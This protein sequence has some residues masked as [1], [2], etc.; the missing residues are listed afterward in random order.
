MLIWGRPV[1][2]LNTESQS[3][4]CLWDSLHKSTNKQWVRILSVYTHT[5]KTLK[6]PLVP[7][8]AE[9]DPPTRL[10]LTTNHSTALCYNV[11]LLI[12]INYVT[13]FNSYGM[14]HDKLLLCCFFMPSA[15]AVWKG[16][17]CMHFFNWIII[18]YFYM[19]KKGVLFSRMNEW[20][21]K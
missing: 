5:R 2:N 16:L 12:A 14:Q 20:M 9:W 3:S 13:F 1:L 8:P 7:E 17:A 4:F 15:D 18:F 21:H 6:T 10:L 11:L 19:R